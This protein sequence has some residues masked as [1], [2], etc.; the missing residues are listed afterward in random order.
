MEIKYGTGRTFSIQAEHVYKVEPEN[1]AK[2][3]E[4][5]RNMKGSSLEF[6]VGPDHYIAVGLSSGA[7]LSRDDK[8]T[9]GERPAK[10]GRQRDPSGPW[11]G[12]DKR[13]DP[14]EMAKLGIEISSP[15]AAIRLGATA[16]GLMFAAEPSS[17]EQVIRQVGTGIDFIDLNEA[18]RAAAEDPKQNLVVQS[19]SKT[20]LVS[21]DQLFGSVP[22]EGM[23]VVLEDPAT[24]ARI[25]GL[26][27]L[28]EVASAPPPEK[29]ELTPEQK[30]YKTLNENLE[31]ERRLKNLEAAGKV[32]TGAA[33]AATD[34]LNR[35]LR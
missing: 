4:L 33:G 34:G 12:E 17:G 32:L 21:N 2:V 25:N 30:Y 7:Y 26:V 31:A 20:Y 28:S 10:P 23:A 13:R 29:A 16:D 18:K 6:T 3:E 11:W 9:F 5:A 27:K 1:A 22:Y 24:K 8:M 35:V 14:A 15:P 19:E